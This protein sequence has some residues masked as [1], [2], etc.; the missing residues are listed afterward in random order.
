MDQNIFQFSK[1]FSPLFDKSFSHG[2]KT[3]G[4]RNI[5]CI[6]DGE[7]AIIIKATR[8]DKKACAIKIT[9]DRNEIRNIRSFIMDMT[10]RN[11][12]P[13]VAKVYDYWKERS[14][15]LSDQ[16][17]SLLAQKYTKLPRKMMMIESELYDGEYNASN[18]L[19]HVCILILCVGNLAECI[20]LRNVLYFE[21]N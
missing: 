9:D 8:P 4:Y 12:H 3:G 7:F 13:N 14:D 1:I 21:T 16:L 19:Y 6:G 15:R 20:N 11:G 5:R 18:Q 2:Y 17:K 10:G